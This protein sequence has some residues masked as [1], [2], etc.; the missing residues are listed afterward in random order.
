MSSNELLY[1]DLDSLY[2]DEDETMD[3]SFGEHFRKNQ[4]VKEYKTPKYIAADPRL[5]ALATLIM[6]EAIENLATDIQLL[7]VNDKFGLVRLRLGSELRAYRKVHGLAMEGLAV[8]FKDWSKLD[9]NETL[10]EQGGRFSHT[11]LNDSFDI[12]TSFM[13]SIK[14][15]SV[16]IRILY[17]SSLEG[18]IGDLGFPPY[19]LQSIR[20]VLNL[21]EGLI[22]LTGGTG[23]GKT[24]TMYTGI[25]DILRRSQGTKNVI[26]I[27]N[28]VEYIIANAVQS[29]VDNL[30]GYTFAKGLQVSLRQNPDVILVGEINDQ[31]TAETA[32]RAS[33]SGHLVFS[34]LHAND[35][36]SASTVM[37]HYQVSPFQLSWALQ[38]VINQ[39]LPRKL[40]GE[41]K[42]QHFVSSDELNWIGKLG[43][44]EEMVS[45]YR[46]SS[47]G[48]EQCEYTGY[49]GRVLVVGMLDAN[50]AYTKI[51]VK[52]LSLVDMET[53]L[54]ENDDARYY[55]MR[56]DVHR[57]LKEGNIDLRTAYELV[58]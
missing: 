16:S 35:A 30:L 36:L 31:E 56:L 24:T 14:G 13:P 58:R 54:L 51:A 38:L 29:Q 7:Q 3:I 12:R 19:V 4:K 18:D 50:D 47:D 28:P 53:E 11:Y 25:N 26:T 34:T 21:Q 33:T 40:C 20:Q 5:H 8:I 37:E 15:E 32:V 27:E 1:V 10:R 49:F 22:L 17:S 46:A 2:Y 41:C 43:V 44:A 55:P 39:K 23:S 6:N 9:I 45:V 48:C 42:V 57:H 52:G